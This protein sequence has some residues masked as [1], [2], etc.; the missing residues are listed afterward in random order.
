LRPARDFSRKSRFALRLPD[1]GGIETLT[2]A[3]VSSHVLD[4]RIFGR[5]KVKLE[6]NTSPELEEHIKTPPMVFGGAPWRAR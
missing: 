5:F 4:A 2:I 6:A 1:I 3:D